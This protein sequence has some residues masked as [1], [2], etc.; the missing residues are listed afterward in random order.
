MIAATTHQRLLCSYVALLTSVAWMTCA[1]ESLCRDTDLSDAFEWRYYPK[2]TKS[3][4]LF[5]KVTFEEENGSYAKCPSTI[6][7]AKSHQLGYQTSVYINGAYTKAVLETNKCRLMNITESTNVI[8]SYYSKIRKASEPR[9]VLIS[10]VGDS[11]QGQLA[12]AM[13]C[14]MEQLSL[15]SSKRYKVTTI[16]PNTVKLY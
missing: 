13:H 12:I 14:W 10:V 8:S 2:K 5:T 9:P 4:H 7:F 3:Y 1:Q 16:C 15:L 11:L 6:G